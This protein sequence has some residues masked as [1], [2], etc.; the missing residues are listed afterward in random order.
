MGCGGG[1]EEQ[2]AFPARRALLLH[3]QV[4]RSDRYADFV[5]HIDG[6]RAYDLRRLSI[7][8]NEKHAYRACGMR[9]FDFLCNNLRRE[10][11]I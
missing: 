11:I 8:C 3:D 4:C 9:V 7:F 1:Q 10:K 6:N 2:R 5:P